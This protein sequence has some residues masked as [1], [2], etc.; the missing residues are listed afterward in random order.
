MILTPTA[1]A[2]LLIALTAFV[3]GAVRADVVLSQSN[4]PRLEVYDSIE[5]RFRREEEAIAMPDGAG[6]FVAPG[7][8]QNTAAARSPAGIRYDA[9]FLDALPKAS[10]GERW[11][12]LAEALYFEARG[13]EVKGM[14]AVAEVILNRVDSPRYPNTV[15]DVIYQGT[16]RLFECQ[17]TYSCDGQPETILEKRAYETVAK[18]A[19]VML[20][21]APR[22][23]T[24]GAT[25]YHT[26]SVRPHWSRVYPRTTTIGYH[27]FY[28]QPER[29][30]LN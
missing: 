13:E 28:R 22:S 14:F 19:R 8:I 26:K 23:L 11:R 21:G 15:C 9:D 27:I 2:M 1:W 7:R 5:E 12:C 16:G 10:G 25:H 18:V 24:D 3:P 29:Y 6:P 20:D 30:A 4:S 17:F